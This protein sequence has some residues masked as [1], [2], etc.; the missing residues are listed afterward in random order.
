MS[1]HTEILQA[2][3]HK[4]AGTHYL[5]PAFRGAAEALDWA[6]HWPI[7]DGRGILTGA[8]VDSDGCADMANVGDLAMVRIDDLGEAEE[9]R[10]REAQETGAWDGYTVLALEEPVFPIFMI[11]VPHQR[12]A[13]LYVA[14]TES[15]FRTIC[16]A[17]AGDDWP[18]PQ[19]PTEDD[20]VEAWEHDLHSGIL[21]HGE[22]EALA[23]LADDRSFA[24]H[25]GARVEVLLRREAREQGWI[26]D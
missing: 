11:A 26:E 25:Q 20:L 19:A 23:F 3:C 6:Q 15:Q 12:P 9:I 22:A 10:I 21:L 5:A 17:N 2:F 13:S 18:W 1:A 14:W 4:W 16:E 24:R 7:V 8:V